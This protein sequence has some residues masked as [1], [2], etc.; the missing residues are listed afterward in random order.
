MAKAAKIMNLSEEHIFAAFLHDVCEI[1]F[2]D[3]SVGS[4]NELAKEL[5]KLDYNAKDAKFIVKHIKELQEQQG[6]SVEI[7][8]FLDSF[9]TSEVKDEKAKSLIKKILLGFLLEENPIIQFLEKLE[10]NCLSLRENT[11]NFIKEVF[12]STPFNNINYSLQ[13]LP[14][15][16]DSHEFNRITKLNC[17]KLQ[18][19]FI[20]E[21]ISKYENIITKNEEN[22]EKFNQL[23]EILSDIKENGLKQEN[24]TNLLKVFKHNPSKII[25]E[26]ISYSECKTLF[27]EVQK[28][29]DYSYNLGSS[30]CRLGGEVFTEL[31]N[32]S[33]QIFSKEIAEKDKIGEKYD[34]QKA[35]LSHVLQ[36]TAIKGK[37]TSCIRELN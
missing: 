21:F 20:H 35:L 7:K 24:F 16:L 28:A 31:T 13:F 34:T 4:R 2:G 10:T 17:I 26:T 37:I 33:F 15:I 18:V 1:P 6:I 27:S 14:E 36:Q 12:T 19:A 32:G 25:T 11:T 22:S 29:S 5:E 8:N 23:K 9:N 30:R 3:V